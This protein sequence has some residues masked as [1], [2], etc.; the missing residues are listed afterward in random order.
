[1]K[2]AA[3]LAGRSKEKKKKKV[4]YL[5]GIKALLYSYYFVASRCSSRHPTGVKQ[6]TMRLSFVMKVKEK[7][8]NFACTQ[9][10]QLQQVADLYQ[11]S[12]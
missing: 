12:S 2:S 1:M 4:R 8:L 10:S 6:H 3:R 7:F 5:Y 11:L 9:V